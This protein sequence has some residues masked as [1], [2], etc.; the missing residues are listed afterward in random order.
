MIIMVLLTALNYARYICAEKNL[1]QSDKEKFLYSRL[2]YIER[3]EK[4]FSE[5]FQVYEKKGDVY[6]NEAIRSQNK[7]YY[8]RAKN[9][10]LSSLAL[11]P[12]SSKIYR[13]MAFICEEI[14]DMCQA[15]KMYL[16]VIENYPAKKQ[17]YLE[18]AVFY[19]RQG[20][21]KMF[22]YY[23]EKSRYLSAATKEEEYI[24][25]AYTKWIESQK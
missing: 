3:A 12:Y 18:A 19:K 11:N 23:Y 14:G 8:K 25:D 9:F 17:Y 1:L 7:E 13:K 21:K 22:E 6:L 24:N 15:E 20:N 10:Y 16:K 2:L 4:L 5:N